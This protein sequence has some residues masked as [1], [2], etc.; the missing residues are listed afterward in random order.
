MIEVEKLEGMADRLRVYDVDQN[1]W[2]LDPEGKQRGRLR[3]NMAHVGLHLA[4]VIER[5]DFFDTRIV[6]SEIAPDSMQYALRLARWGS[7]ALEEIVPASIDYSAAM[8]LQSRLRLNWI[9]SAPLASFIKAQGVLSRQ[10]HSEDHVN[11]RKRAYD[12]R[13]EALGEVAGLL[14]QTAC[15]QAN[16]D[17][18]NEQ[19]DIVEA[20]D[21]RLSHLRQR[22]GIPEPDA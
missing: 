15:M 17:P 6:R 5:K 22:F 7:V 4:D 10:L 13:P 12:Q 3:H 21:L 19:F 20:F 9:G 14:V 11:T 18:N 8:S 2:E 1:G 16:N